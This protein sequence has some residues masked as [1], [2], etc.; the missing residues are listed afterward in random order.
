MPIDYELY[1]REYVVLSRQLRTFGKCANCGAENNVDHPDT[2]SK[3]VLTVHHLDCDIHNNQI[4]NL[5]PLCQRCHLGIHHGRVTDL[6]L[7]KE[8]RTWLDEQLEFAIYVAK[9][10]RE[11]EK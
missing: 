8:Y 10:M 5:A 6:K 1:G 7:S 3:V 11:V 4:L 2:G 9:P